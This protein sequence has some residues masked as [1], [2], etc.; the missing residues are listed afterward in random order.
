MDLVK[1]LTLP[2]RCSIRVWNG[3]SIFWVVHLLGTRA[4][5]HREPTNLDYV[6]IQPL[7]CWQ[8]PNVCMAIL[9]WLPL[10]LPQAMDLLQR[11][12]QDCRFE[13]PSLVVECHR[14]AMDVF[15]RD[16]VLPRKSY[17]PATK[18]QHRALLYVIATMIR[19]SIGLIYLMCL[20]WEERKIK[21]TIIAKYFHMHTKRV[22]FFCHSRWHRSI[23]YG[24][25]T[26]NRTTHRH[27][28]H[29]LEV[30]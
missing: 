13:C 28:S 14:S 16:H 20:Q 5:T 10:V 3:S 7:H 18:H 29:N 8:S 23:P 4:H 15:A 27:K 17:C 22:L 19:L 30:K 9:D 24:A 21:E 25:R 6:S 11:R 1:V 2:K 26:R 12:H